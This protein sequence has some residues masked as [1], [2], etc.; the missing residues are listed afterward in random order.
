MI[1]TSLFRN[2]SFIT[3]DSVISWLIKIYYEFSFLLNKRSFGN[4]WLSI[5]INRVNLKAFL[6]SRWWINQSNEYD[7]KHVFHFILLLHKLM[8]SLRQSWK[9]LMVKTASEK[10]LLNSYKTKSTKKLIKLIYYVFIFLNSIARTSYF[11]SKI[12]FLYYLFSCPF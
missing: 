4:F 10:K 2:L 1:T 12:K 8:K 7:C 6:K 5:F 11:L 9:H 3:N